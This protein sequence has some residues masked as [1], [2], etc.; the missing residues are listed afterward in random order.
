MND[1]Q[2]EY[3][4]TPEALA[5]LCARLADSPFLALDTEFMRESTYRPQL[6]LLQ[7]ATDRVLA[8]VDP[9]ALPDLTPLLD[10]LY[11]PRVTKVL[12][13]A[14][15]DLEILAILR[16]EPPPTVFDT[17]IAA[18]LLGH[19]DQVG[20]AGLVRAVLGVSLDKGHARTD[21]SVRPLSPEQLRY[22]ADDVRYLVPLYH[23][24][25]QAL[26]ESE[27]LDWLD[28]DFAALSD[29]AV[30]AYAPEEAWRRVRGLN[31][32]RGRQRAILRALAAWREERAHEWDKPRRWIIGDDALLELARQAPRKLERMARIRGLDPATL[33]HHGQTLLT[34]IGQA[35]ASPPESWPATPQTAPLSIEQE[36]LCDALMAV[37]RLCALDHRVTSGNLANR[38]DLERVV[39]GERD[40]ALLH[41]WRKAI[42]GGEALALLAGERC[43]GVRDGVLR[44]ERGE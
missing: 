13:S 1:L 44:L 9:L 31:A 15:Q 5:G 19:G 23:A 32:L 12:H 14:R 20:Y 10:R 11:D 27:R 39:K 34:L 4:D 2:A 7:V 36:A 22:A 30:Y 41:G 37:V 17:Q 21:W 3:I 8:C 42:A 24:V 18:T 29:P 6:C 35:Q 33:R 25:H 43:L 28:E 16:G 40:V 38:R 26:V